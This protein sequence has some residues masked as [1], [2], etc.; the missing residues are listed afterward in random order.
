MSTHVDILFLNLIIFFSIMAC[1]RILN[2]VPCATQLDLV[3]YPFY[4]SIYNAQ[5]NQYI[6]FNYWRKQ[7]ICLIT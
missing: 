7:A 6:N 5:K 1:H 4:V 3:V 2:I